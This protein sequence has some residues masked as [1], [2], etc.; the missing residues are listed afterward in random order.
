VSAAPVVVLEA[1]VHDRPHHPDG[2]RGVGARQRAQV[3]VR[4]TRGAAAERV[5][6]HE[7]R[8]LLARVEQLSP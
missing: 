8:A 2:E 3:L 1:R 6:N 4:H 5:H 7:P